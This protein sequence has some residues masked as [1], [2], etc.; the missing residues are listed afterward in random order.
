[1]SKGVQTFQKLLIKKSW[2]KTEGRRES[3][4]EDSEINVH[5]LRRVMNGFPVTLKK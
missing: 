3:G 5:K 1:M 4:E 2:K